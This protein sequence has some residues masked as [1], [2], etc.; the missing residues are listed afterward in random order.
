MPARVGRQSAE[1]RELFRQRIRE[2]VAREKARINRRIEREVPAWLARVAKPLAD[3]ALEVQ[4]ARDDAV[5]RAGETRAAFNF[6]LFLPASWTVFNDAVLEPRP[7]E[8]IQIDHLL[9][10]PPGVYLVETKAWAGAIKCY[11]GV[12]KRREGGSWV[13]SPS[14]TRQNLRHA[15][16]FRAWLDAALHGRLPPGTLVHPV[17]LFTRA[18]WLRV[19]EGPMPVFDSGLA[20]AWHLRSQSRHVVLNPEQVD[21]IAE[22]VASARPWTPSEAPAS[23]LVIRPLQGE[24]RVREGRTRDGRRY[25]TVTGSREDAEEVRQRYVR[26]GSRPGPLQR[27]CQAPERWFFYL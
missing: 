18:E 13:P 22:A 27:D 1:V 6:W 12:W 3:V 14:P 16:L 24:A 20:L 21:L 5:G 25:V 26:E 19:E 9:I 15:H 7:E 17:L 2:K 10:G 23:R 4:R 11:R 8:F